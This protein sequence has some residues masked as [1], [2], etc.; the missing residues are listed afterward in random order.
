MCLVC[1]VFSCWRVF[2]AAGYGTAA[3]PQARSMA[4]PPFW[5]VS[6]LP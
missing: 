4:N 5:P 6:E 2:S 3:S 1:L